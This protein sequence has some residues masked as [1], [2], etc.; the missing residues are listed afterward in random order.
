VFVASGRGTLESYVINERPHP[1]WDAPYA[2]AL[3]Q[4]EE[5]VRMMSNIVGCPQTPEALQLDMALEVS[6]KV[7]SDT[8]S[9]PLFRPLGSTLMDTRA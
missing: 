7:M 3:V 9:L 4:L 5:G 8:I 2:I 1:A 6:F